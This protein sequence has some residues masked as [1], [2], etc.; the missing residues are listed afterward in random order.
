MYIK[1]L[2]YIIVNSNKKT[3]ENFGSKYSYHYLINVLT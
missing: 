1:V 2:K 3:Y